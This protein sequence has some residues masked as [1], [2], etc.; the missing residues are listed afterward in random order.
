MFLPAGQ[1]LQLDRVIEVSGPRIVCEM[2]IDAGHWVFP[3]H[4]PGD[5]VF[6]G[7]LLIEAAGQ[8]VAV[9]G[10][11]AGLRGNPR[12]A[13]VS[14]SFESP[15]IAT[16]RRLRLTGTVR[17]RRGICFGAVEITADGRAVATVETVIAV[18][19]RCGERLPALA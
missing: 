18:V 5:P 17:T 14:A 3:L 8:T 19:A 13:K 12:M 9:H 15:V 10:W 16:D 6:P 1:M 7:C 4:F 11:H 2:D